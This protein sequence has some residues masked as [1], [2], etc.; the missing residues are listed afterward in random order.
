M[1]R[2]SWPTGF[3][4]LAGRVGGGHIDGRWGRSGREKEGWLGGRGIGKQ[5]SDRGM[6]ERGR[7]CTDGWM[8][9]FVCEYREGWSL[10]SWRGRALWKL[11]FDIVTVGHCAVPASSMMSVF[12]SGP[13]GRR[14]LQ[15]A[16]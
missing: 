8:V 13:W 2:G 11:D 6:S 12:S 9:G 16:G 1:S 14:C 4:C 15:L 10:E 5:V 7:G 3:R